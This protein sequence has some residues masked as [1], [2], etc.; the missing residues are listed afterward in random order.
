MPQHIKVCISLNLFAG[1]NC[2]WPVSIFS[3][4]LLETSTYVQVELNVR[5][6]LR[7]GTGVD[8]SFS[9]EGKS[10]ISLLHVKNSGENVHCSMI[11]VQLLNHHLVLYQILAVEE[12]SLWVLRLCSWSLI[13]GAQ[14]NFLA[15]VGMNSSAFRR[16]LNSLSMLFIALTSIH[17]RSTIPLDPV[18]EAY[19][20]RGLGAAQVQLSRLLPDLAF[21][22]WHVGKSAALAES[23]V[24]LSH[25]KTG[26]PCKTKEWWESSSVCCDW[27]S[28][29]SSPAAEMLCV[30][31]PRSPSLRGCRYYV[32]CRCAGCSSAGLSSQLGCSF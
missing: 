19:W 21:S 18:S 2:S 10:P 8:T 31:W 12:G 22:Y 30:I 24:I 25:P 13:W 3:N 5:N 29:T 28:V 11:L 23:R 9:A 1:L 20:A 26:K 27:V 6:E 4:L 7:Q 17:R 16:A 15:N 32:K 14:I